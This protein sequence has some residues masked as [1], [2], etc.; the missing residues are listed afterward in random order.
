MIYLSGQIGI[1]L[2]RPRPGL[3]VM[4][5]PRSL[6]GG[7]TETVVRLGIPWAADN[8]AFTRFDEGRWLDWLETMP[9]AARRLCLF[10]AAP[11]VVG[12]AAATLE[13][14]RPY[15]PVIRA[16]GYPVAYVAQDGF[17]PALVPWDAIDWLFV[18]GAAR[19]SKGTPQRARARA[20]SLEWK[21]SELALA[22]IGAAK[23]RGK[24]VHV[25]R[26]NGG[27]MLR[28]FAVAGADSADGTKLVFGGEKNYAMVAA[29][30]DG[31]AAQPP[32]ELLA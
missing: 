6:R 26:V 25:G 3:G 13:R 29:W 11:D 8:D 18:G 20:L 9:E 24:R 12:D 7:Q 28:R 19:A 2:A 14:S 17:D 30:L 22:A 21:R 27:R 10:A 5:N 31:L 15:L 16:L 32:L 4:A 23:R 1:V